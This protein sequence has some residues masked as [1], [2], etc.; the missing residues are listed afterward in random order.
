MCLRYCVSGT[1]LS[2][3]M[4]KNHSATIPYCTSCSQLLLSLSTSKMLSS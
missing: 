2:I 1:E 3:G 4:V